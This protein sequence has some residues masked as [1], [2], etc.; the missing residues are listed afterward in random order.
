MTNEQLEKS[1]RL[2]KANNADNISFQKSYIDKL[3][4]PDSSSDVVI[5]NGVIN[6][7][8]DKAGVFKEAARILKPGGRL[9]IADIVTEKQMPESITCNTTLWAACIGG[10]VQEDEY[11][12]MIQDCGLNIQKVRRNSQ[13]GFISK[14]AR[15]ATDDYGVKSISILAVKQ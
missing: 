14:S 11:L 6:L 13:Y 1:E 9:A 10:A 5:S 15:G 2:S 3:Q 4:L 8:H 12:K 7:A